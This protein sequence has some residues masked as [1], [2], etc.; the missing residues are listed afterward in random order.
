M[1]KP[2]SYRCRPALV[3]QL[4]RAWR[5]AQ[6]LRRGGSSLG[7]SVCIRQPL[8]SDVRAQGRMVFGLMGLMPWL[9]TLMAYLRP[10]SLPVERSDVASNQ[11]LNPA[12]HQGRNSAS[13]QV[14]HLVLWTRVRALVSVENMVRLSHLLREAPLR[15]FATC[16]VLIVLART[17]TRRARIRFRR[18]KLHPV[19][20]AELF[21]IVV[22]KFRNMDGT[23]VQWRLP[24]LDEN[25]LYPIVPKKAAWYLDKNRKSPILRITRSQLPLAPAFAM[26]AHASQGQTLRGG[27]IVDLCIGHGSNPLGSYV[28]LTRVTCREK[29][30]I[31]RLVRSRENFL[32]KVHGKVQSCYCECCVARR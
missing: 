16:T 24:G 28:A 21:A 31:Y 13:N 9:C 1:L 11:V 8:M 10:G 23:D 19:V 30:S 5:V 17:G 25:G 14:L 4:W 2:K 7:A 26:T 20:A 27:A 3:V 15:L 29:L 18:L 32:H 12:S 6:A 22:I